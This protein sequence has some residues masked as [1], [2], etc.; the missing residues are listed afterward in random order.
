M[1]D[2]K[3]V[4]AASRKRGQYQFRAEPAI[5]RTYLATGEEPRHRLEIISLARL[6]LKKRINPIR[7]TV[8]SRIKPI[9]INDCGCIVTVKRV[10]ELAHAANMPGFIYSPLLYLD[11]DMGVR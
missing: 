3:Q 2:V 8:N 1:I 10:S 11:G 6:L 4:N 7:I 9:Y 5:I